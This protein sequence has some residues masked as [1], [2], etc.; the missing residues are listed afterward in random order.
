MQHP[1][2]LTQWLAH[3][4]QLHPSTIDMGLERLSRVASRMHGGAGVRFSCPVFTVAG[5]NGKGSTCAMLESILR[6]SGYRTGM[7]TSPHLVHFTERCQIDRQPVDEAT[8]CPHFAAV[9]AA[10][11]DISLSY[12]EFTTLA[13]LDC[14]ASQPLDAVILEVGMGGRLDAV[15]LVDTDCAIITCIDI[16][17]VEYL[18]NTREAIAIEKAGIMRP[19]KPAI[20][21]D[22]LPPHTLLEHAQSIGA[23]LWLHG[24]DFATEGDRQQWSWQGRGR[25]YAGL[26]YPALRGANQIVNAAGVLAALAAMRERLPVTAQGIRMGPAQVALQGRFQVIAGQPTLILDVAHN[27]HSVATLTASLDAMGYHPATHA[28]CG[29]MH[30]KDLPDMLRRMHPLVDHWYFTD[31]PT[32]RAASAA[33]LQTLWQSTSAHMPERLTTAS[34]QTFASPEQALQAA[35]TAAAAADRIVVFGSFFTVGG[36]LQ[37][38]LP[39]PPA[40]TP[41]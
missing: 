30:D 39:K 4:E 11:G 19:G 21:G 33:E 36:V 25:R 31:L 34:S 37:A 12:F 23:D 27:P 41:D 20:V 28:V 22:P 15:N 7:F 6:H 32:E 16:D 10:R 17:H 1:Q 9:E 24:R 8:L 18:G 2:T 13:I 38:G 29:A 14:L 26:A 35:L 5:T 40:A 3:C